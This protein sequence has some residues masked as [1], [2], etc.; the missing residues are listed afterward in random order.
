MALGTALLI[1]RIATRYSFSL[2]LVIGEAVVVWH[3]EQ[4]SQCK[5][6]RIAQFNVTRAPHQIA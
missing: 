1:S 3:I 4:P 6:P 2:W 5:N